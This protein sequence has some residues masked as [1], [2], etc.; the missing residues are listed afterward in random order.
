MCQ[1]NGQKSEEKKYDIY[2]AERNALI[3]AEREGARLFDKAILTL[4]AGSFGLSLALIKQI[5]PDIKNGSTIW[6]ILGWGGFC[7]SLLSTLISFL[8]SQAACRKQREILEQSYLK[9]GNEEPNRAGRITQLLNILSITFFVLGIVFS[10]VFIL[11]N[12]SG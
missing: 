12:I 6:L 8:T 9:D 2:F 11:T 4:A 5:V 1:E 10:A 3:D 7:L